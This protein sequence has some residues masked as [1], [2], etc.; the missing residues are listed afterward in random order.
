MP[1]C[2][3]GCLKLGRV[4][5]QMVAFMHFKIQRLPLPIEIGSSIPCFPALQALNNTT[6]HRFF[7]IKDL[8]WRTSYPNYCKQASQT[9]RRPSQ[10]QHSQHRVFAIALKKTGAILYT[11]HL[12]T[13]WPCSVPW[14]ATD[15]VMNVSDHTGCIWACTF[16]YP[17]LPFIPCPECCHLPCVLPP[18]LYV[19]LL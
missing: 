8:L 14:Y 3:Q 18:A 6:P 5:S 9:H 10:A 4:L 16:L 13:C 15:L 2:L 19:S 11:L 1:G 12:H 17:L 7:M